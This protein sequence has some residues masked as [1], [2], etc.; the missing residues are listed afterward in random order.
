MSD[1]A[2]RDTDASVEG[3]LPGDW[4]PVL[5]KTKCSL[6][7]CYFYENEWVVSGSDWKFRLEG[8]RWCPI[9]PDRTGKKQA[10]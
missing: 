7:L 10:P 5:V 6:N 1:V 3:G 4:Q 8:T 2:W 9:P